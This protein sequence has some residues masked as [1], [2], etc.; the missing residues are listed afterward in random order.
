[1]DVAIDRAA[2]GDTSTPWAK[3]DAVAAVAPLLARI[4]SA[5]ERHEYC[6]RLALA[7]RSEAR[8]VEAAVRAAGRGDDARDAVPVAARRDGPEERNLRQLA[9]SLFEHPALGSRV[10]RD[11]L[12][13][14]VAPC[15]L[16]ELIF[17][18]VDA[19][20]A[21]GGLDVEAVA[22]Q[23]GDE[24]RALLRS[25]AVDDE[26][27]DEEVARKTVDD[28]L[29]WLRKRQ[30]KRQKREL[31]QQLRDPGADADAVLKEKQRLISEKKPVAH[32]PVGGPL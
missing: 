11:E 4:P 21:G 15:P 14:L 18:L 2:A 5:V 20:A 17:A 28:T 27:L 25:L 22:A 10:G 3:A 31:T 13:A 12:A 7:V 16:G 19:G 1:M 26:A 32:S 29:E 23:L 24:A 30:L 9:R 6:N 8:H